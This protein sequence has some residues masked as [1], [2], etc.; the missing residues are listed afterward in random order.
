MKTFLLKISFIFLLACF[1]GAGCEKEDEYE[2]I[3]L[4]NLKCPCDHDAAFIKKISRDNILLFDA[5]KTTWGEMKAQTF[6]GEK[7]EFISYTKETKSMIFYA[8]RTTMIGAS[9]ICNIPTKIDNW[10]VPSAGVI[11]SFD[12]NEFESCVSQGGIS[13]NTNSD[14]TLTTFKRKI[15]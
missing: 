7:S 4:E 1:V 12:A 8:V 3:Q 13:N 2:N 6:D 15:K 10:I 14:C 11:I 5:E 9:N